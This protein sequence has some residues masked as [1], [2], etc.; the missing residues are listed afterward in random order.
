[1]YHTLG[2]HLPW[3]DIYATSSYSVLCTVQA[4]SVKQVGHLSFTPADEP[5]QLGVVT[6]PCSLLGQ[7]ISIRSLL[8]KNMPVEFRR[9]A[10]A[11]YIQNLL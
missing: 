8:W 1:M 11:F 7:A 6:S 10:R 3:L 2:T 4:C 5:Q 9:L